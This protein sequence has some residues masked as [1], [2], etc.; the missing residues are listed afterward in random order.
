MKK[1]NIYF[2]DFQQIQKNKLFFQDW[3]S[4]KIH[5]Y[6]SDFWQVK[7]LFRWLLFGW[8][9]LRQ[10]I[11]TK[12]PW[13]KLDAWAFLGHHLTS[14]ALHPGFSIKGHKGQNSTGTRCHSFLV[15]ES[16]CRGFLVLE[17]RCCGFLSS[18]KTP[19]NHDVVTY[20]SPFLDVVVF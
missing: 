10:K 3:A 4:Q 17:F 8:L 12:L 6:F 11:T 19:R 18:E 2:A 20:L 5:S 1:S 9:L 15:L 7:L 13:E 16:R 14:P